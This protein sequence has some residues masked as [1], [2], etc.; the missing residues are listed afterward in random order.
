[1]VTYKDSI[2]ASNITTMSVVMG[3]GL[4]AA[5]LAEIV[6]A[7]NVPGA[8]IFSDIVIV[9]IITSVIISTVGISLIGRK[10]KRCDS[11]LNKEKKKKL[12]SIR[13]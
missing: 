2:L 11:E 1:M 5:V 12:S 7:S 3:R 9:V 4:A 6:R 8:S 10:I 13:S